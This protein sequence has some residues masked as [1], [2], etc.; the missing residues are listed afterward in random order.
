[1]LK[2]IL[3][4]FLLLVTILFTY[5][6]MNS[7][8]WL[9]EFNDDRQQQSIVLKQQGADFAKA[10]NQDQCLEQSFKQLGK[11]YAYG[12][13]LDQGVFLK[14]CLANAQSS[15]HFCDGIARYKEKPTEDDKRWLKNSCWD[16][17]VNAE[18]CRFLLK[19]KVYF[20]SQ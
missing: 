6:W 1:M 8:Q 14:S 3:W 17:N 13:T 9:E 20:C 10:A 2:N 7:Q 15:E 11:C 18:G 16:K 12:C 4:F 19:Q 5:I